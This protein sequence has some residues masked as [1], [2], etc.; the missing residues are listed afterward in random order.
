MKNNARVAILGTVLLV[1]ALSLVGGAREQGDMLIAVEQLEDN[2]YVLRGEGG[3]GNTGVFVTTTGVV[4]VDT[5]NPGWGQ[6]ILDAIAELTDNPITTLIN[7]HSHGDHV[8]GNVAFPA[9]VDFVAHET[10]KANMDVMRPYTGRTEPPLNVFAD[11][12]GHGLPEITFSERLSLGR[13]ADQVDL[14]YF[15]RGHTGGD[16][17]VVFP[18]LRTLHAGDVFLGKRV[19]FLD[20]AN[21][22]SGVDL[23]DTL[24]RAHDTI[25]DVDTIISG[26]STQMTWDD[27][28]E[29]AAFNRDFLD[30]VRRGHASGQTAEEIAQGWTIPTRYTGYDAP[31]QAGVAR[32]I[33]V[34]IDELT[35]R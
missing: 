16:T 5:K 3:G 9:T 20:A 6:P 23:P 21:G 28:A 29:W 31:N 35:A 10:T 26:H 8:S 13:G 11:T 25:Q 12:N 18:A 30:T 33:Q 14:Y 17:W 7:T 24:Q 27:L 19:P 2:L 34:I 4:V 1:G 22:G 15:G 32:N